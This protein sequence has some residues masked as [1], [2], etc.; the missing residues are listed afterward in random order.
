[1]ELLE[2]IR[3]RKSI[4][5]YKPTPILKEVLIQILEVATRA[6]SN[7]NSQPWE[8]TMLGGE[9]LDN[10]KQA[11]QAQ[12][13]AGAQPSPDFPFQP[14]TG[15]Y[16]NRQVE[17]GVALYQLMNISRED[18][19]KRKEWT[20]RQLRAFDAPNV[21]IVSMDEEISRTQV[22][23]SMFSLGIVSQNIALA[24]LN[25][26]LGTCLQR[27]LIEY[28]DVVRSIAGI[29]ESKRL[30]VGIAIGYPDWDFPA[31]KFQSTREPLA[32]IVTWRGV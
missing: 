11:L 28:P 30:A 15:V 18:T 21:I 22:F 14:L 4:R 19:E 3:S 23:Q 2:A 6:P 25:F 27:I 10:L 7:T 16:R 17:V 31:N 13:L 5:G 1:M 32:N 8:F 29:P 9:V 24:A 26:G 20:L 12:F